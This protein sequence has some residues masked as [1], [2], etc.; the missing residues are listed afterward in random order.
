VATGVAPERPF[1]FYN[2]VYELVLHMIA[3]YFA[4]GH[5]VPGQRQIRA[6]VEAV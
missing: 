2:A 5:E 1:C 6:H 4:F 3:G